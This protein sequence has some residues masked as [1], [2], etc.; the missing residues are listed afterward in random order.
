M[1][2]NISF[3][4]VKPRKWRWYVTGPMFVAL[5]IITLS[6]V[7]ANLFV[8]FVDPMKT[9]AFF[10]NIFLVCFTS[11]VI[12]LGY[13]IFIAPWHAS[14]DERLEI[15]KRPSQVVKRQTRKIFLLPWF[16]MVAGALIGTF[17]FWN[18]FVGISYYVQTAPIFYKVG[19]VAFGSGL[20]ICGLL[21]PYS[22]WLG[23]RFERLFAKRGMCLECGYD[24]RGNIEA[25]HCPECGAENRIADVLKVR[26]R[27]NVELE[28]M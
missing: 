11:V 15:S 20:V 19:T 3:E 16:M 26:E 27:K 18:R 17:P 8:R 7:Y 28:R 22:W 4:R 9:D 21:W 13:V 24:L 10:R 12:C 23:K 2:N 6:V 5:S 14:N 25:A 1:E